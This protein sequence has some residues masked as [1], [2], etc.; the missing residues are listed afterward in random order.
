M[1][2]EIV[3]TIDKNKEFRFDLGEPTI[4]NTYAYEAYK[5]IIEEHR[6][7]LDEQ[8]RE[9]ISLQKEEKKI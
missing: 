1:S 5:K 4:L 8:M 3:L 7:W 6:K 9:I 2:D